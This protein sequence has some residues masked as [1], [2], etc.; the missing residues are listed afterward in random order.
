MSS[1]IKRRAADKSVSSPIAQLRAARAARESG[2]SRIHQYEVEEPEV[3]YDEVD[4]DRVSKRL[5][6]DHNDFVEDDDGSGY[7][8]D[9]DDEERVYYSDEYPEERTS[10]G[11]KKNGKGSAAAKDVLKPKAKEN[12][13]DAFMKAGTQPRLNKPVVSKKTTDDDDFMAALLQD[14]DN[15]VKTTPTKKVRALISKLGPLKIKD[16]EVDEPPRNLASKVQE[17]DYDGFD[18]SYD[19]GDSSWAEVEVKKEANPIIKTEPED[20]NPFQVDEDDYSPPAVKEISIKGSKAPMTLVNDSSKKEKA[21]VV[22]QPEKD[23]RQNWMTVDNNFNQSTSETKVEPETAMDVQESNIKEEDGTL[24]MYWIDACEVR[25]VV[26]LFGKALQKSTNAYVS[27][28]V[29]VHN[30]ERNIFVL[31][32]SHRVDSEGKETNV[33]VDMADVYTEFDSIR[34]AHK[35]TS[36]LS[37]PVER[38]YAFELPGIPSSAEYLKVVYKYSL[39]SLPADLK[40]ETFSH[41][42]GANTSALE[43]FI[44]KRNLM[45]PCWLEINQ[46]RTNN[47]KVSWCKAEFIVDNEKD[48]KPM[49]ESSDLPPPPLVVMSLSLRTV[50]NPKDKANEIVSVS[51][52]VYHEVRLDDPVESNR[53]NVS[54]Q[55][56]I[57]PLTTSPFPVGFDRVVERSK[58]KILKQPSERTLLNLLLANIFRTDPDVI[59]GHNFVGFDLDVLLHRMKHTKADH[60]SRVG[61]LRR[62]IWPKLQTGAGGMGDTT[63]QEKNIVSGRLMCDTYLGAKEHVRAKSYGLTNLV[64]MQLGVNREDIEYERVPQYFNSADDLERML[65]HSDF[66]TYLCAELMFNLQLLPLSRQLTTLSGNLWSITLTAGRAVRNEYLLLHEFHRNKYIC[67]DKSFYKDKETSIINIDADEADEAAAPKKGSKRKPQYSGGLVLEPKKGFYDQYVLLLDFNSLYPSIIQEYNICF[68]T[69]KHDREKDDDT[70]PEYPEEGLPQGIL[71]KLLANLV[72]RRREVKKLMKSAS[73]AKYEEYDIRQKGLKLTANSMYGCLGAAYSRFYAKQLAMLITSRGREILQNTVD[74]ATESGLD[75][76]YG[77]TDSIMINTNTTKMEE[78]KPI[79]ENLKK[80]VNARYKLLEIEM[81]GMYQRMLL[82]KKK[83]YAALMVI[84]KNGKHETVVETKG[85][86]MVRRD[87]C[88]LSQDVSNYVLTQI[89]SSDNQDREHVVENIHNYLRTVGEETRKGLIPMD[90]FVVNK[91][92]TKAPED[93][94]DAKSQPHVQVA[95]R[96]KRKGISVRAGDTV[97]YVICVHDD[98]PVSKGGYADRAYH[99]DEVLVAGSGLT[100]DYEYYL[101]QQVHPPLDRLCG[102]I[103]GTDATRL[104]DCLGL[105]TSKFRSVVRS[106]TQDQELQTLGSQLSDAE[107]YKDAEP[108]ELRC[109]GCHSTFTC[110]SLMMEKDGANYF[111]LQCPSCK[112]IAQPASASIQLTNVIRKSIQK[113]YQGWVVC[114]DQGCRNRTRMY[115]DGGLYTQLSFF[116]HIF[117]INK[118]L[119][120][121][122]FEKNGAVRVQI[123]QNRELVRVLKVTVDKYIDKNARRYVDLSQLFSFVK[124]VA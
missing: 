11:S 103:E 86:D 107:R 76:I 24:R 93:Y 81:D 29:A 52:S 120:K 104:A 25:G 48:I 47:T 69:V 80:I 45:G 70:L 122:D 100:I 121:V 106:D 84:E 64:A 27:C 59:V 1:R 5:R 36:W 124:I 7:T 3:L 85:L 114:D 115:S 77:D 53:R 57:R 123:E 28:C 105:D 41:V 89:L 38:K 54:K 73:G 32:R 43:H 94:A 108:L 35:I 50:I 40:G 95:L 62:T 119:E 49:N 10:K 75:V 21:T 110:T 79:A 113:Y 87:W 20:N 118:A 83:K 58:V 97:P 19:L 82:L 15:G 6:Q 17:T 78:V 72:D 12:I 61:R 66:D 60:W 96:L 68:T 98:A 18:D 30:M 33:E 14:M 16:E 99:P 23:N 8:F 56:Y 101:N 42:F 117:D 13:R 112:T 55:T 9:D 91:G 26:Y 44:I 46:T 102:P 65:R 34:Q 39:P 74:L 90:K 4:D 109:R 116:S 51:T 71:P 63:A 111:G 37:K 92:L 22:K 31:P 67:P 2:I 88:G